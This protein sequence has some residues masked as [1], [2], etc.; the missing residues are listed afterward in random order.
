MLLFTHFHL[1][2]QRRYI[3]PFL[4]FS[5]TPPFLL[6]AFFLFAIYFLPF[7]LLLPF[8]LSFPLKV[9][10]IGIS[11]LCSSASPSPLFLTLRPPPTVLSSPPLTTF[12]NPPHN[13]H[14]P[15]PLSLSSISIPTIPPLNDGSVF[16]LLFSFFFGHNKYIIYKG[17][18]KSSSTI[19]CYFHYPLSTIT[20]TREGN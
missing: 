14:S 18:E 8:F 11:L 10:G 9:I 4:F 12:I 19:T 6:F 16:I 20:I 13:P 15:T 1:S 2:L 3:P 5:F 17:A 7:L